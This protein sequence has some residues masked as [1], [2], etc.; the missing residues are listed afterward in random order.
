MNVKVVYRSTTGNTEKL[1]HEIA[2]TLNIQAEQLRFANMP[3]M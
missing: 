2:D 1:A 3:K